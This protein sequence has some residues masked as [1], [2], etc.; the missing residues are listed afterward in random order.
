MYTSQQI[1]ERGDTHQGTEELQISAT[2][3]DAHSSS[4]QAQ[5]RDALRRPMA[6]TASYVPYQMWKYHMPLRS[7]QWSEQLF[8]IYVISFPRRK[9]RHSRYIEI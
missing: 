5:G 4:A 1:L 9:M 3:N 6:L 8:S 2:N 7:P